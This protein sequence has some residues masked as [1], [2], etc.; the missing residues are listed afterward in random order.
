MKT[1]LASTVTYS[2]WLCY[3]P[4][5]ITQFVITMLVVEDICNPSVLG[6]VEGAVTVRLA[7]FTLLHFSIET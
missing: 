4:V 6:L 2:K 7:T 3:L 1:S 5:L